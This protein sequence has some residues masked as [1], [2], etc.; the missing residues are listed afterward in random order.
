VFFLFPTAHFFIQFFT[1]ALWHIGF[2]PG[3]QKPTLRQN[4]KS[5]FSNAF[6]LTLH[7]EIFI[8]YISPLCSVTD[9]STKRGGGQMFSRA[10]NR[11]ITRQSK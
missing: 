8:L 7:R 5:H 9:S 1:T 10:N 11:T 2:C 3:T 4:P 6:F